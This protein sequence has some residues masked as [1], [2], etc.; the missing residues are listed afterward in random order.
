MA[1]NLQFRVTKPGSRTSSKDKTR[2][3]AYNQVEGLLSITQ[4]ARLYVAS[5][6]TLYRK[7][8]SCR[9]QVS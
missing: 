9:D 5:K 8:N 4:G 7:I 3:R 1:P 6:T 2:E